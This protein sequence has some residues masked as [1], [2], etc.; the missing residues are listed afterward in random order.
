MYRKQTARHDFVVVHQHLELII[1][2]DNKRVEMRTTI[3]KIRRYRLIRLLCV[4]L[5]KMKTLVRKLISERTFP[6]KSQKRVCTVANI[7]VVTQRLPYIIML[8]TLISPQHCKEVANRN[9]VCDSNVHCFVT[10]FLSS[11]PSPYSPH[12]STQVRTSITNNLVACHF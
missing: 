8:L 3:V 11:S 9:A 6:T 4:M 12:P 7:T 10:L 2:V 1:R 5:L